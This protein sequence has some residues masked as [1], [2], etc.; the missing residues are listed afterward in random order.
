MADCE[1]CAVAPDTPCALHRPKVEPAFDESKVRNAATNAMDAALNLAKKMHRLKEVQAE[2][3]AAGLTNDD[4]VHI[5]NAAANGRHDGLAALDLF[6][7]R[8]T[9]PTNPTTGGGNG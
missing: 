1:Y 2:A 9:E 4:L 5:V 6:S 3:H 7:L 8:A